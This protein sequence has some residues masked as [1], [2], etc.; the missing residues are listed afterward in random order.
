MNKNYSSCILLNLPMKL[1]YAIYYQYYVTC[2]HY[3]YLFSKIILFEKITMNW[4]AENSK[5]DIAIGTKRSLQ[6]SLVLQI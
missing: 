3:N 5:I 4:N 6:F 1:F 2:Y